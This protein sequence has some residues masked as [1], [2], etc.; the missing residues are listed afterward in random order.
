MRKIIPWCACLLTA[1]LLAS[2]CG[3]VRNS[4]SGKVTFG[5]RPVAGMVT[6]V[7]ADGK[8]ATAPINPDGSYTV[9]NPP[10]GQVQVVVKNFP[11]MAGGNQPKPNPRLPQLP[12]SV[13]TA[14]PLGVAP[15]AKY[16]APSP[17]LTFTVTGG[18]QTYDVEL[19]R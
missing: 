19:T 5:G 16:A 18:R 1:A 12:G 17:A 11:G 10:A 3:G 4:V 9:V 8:E 2:G 13:T 15:P 6:F 7:G 14:A